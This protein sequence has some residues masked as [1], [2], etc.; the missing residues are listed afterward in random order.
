MP[1]NRSVRRSPQF[2][3]AE[4]A[5]GVVGSS[6]R[7]VSASRPSPRARPTGSRSAIANGKS[8]PTTTWVRPKRS[9]RLADRAV[10]VDEAVD[11]E[12]RAPSRPDRPCTASRSAGKVSQACAQA[13]QQRAERAAA[14]A[15]GDAQARMP[16]RACRRSAARRPRARSRPGRPAPAAAAAGRPGAPC[17]TGRSGCT[18]IAAPSRSAAAKNG[19]S[20][21]SPRTTPLMLVPISTPARPSGAHQRVRARRRAVDVLQRHRAE[22]EE[23]AG[24]ARHHAGDLLV[25]VARQAP[26]RPRRRAS[27]TAAP[28]SATA[29]ADRPAARPCR[30]HASRRP[31]MCRA[32]CGRPC[33]RASRG[34]G[35]RAPAPS[36]ARRRRARRAHTAGSP[37][38]RRGCGC[39]CRTIAVAHD[40]D[41]PVLADTTNPS[42]DVSMISALASRRFRKHRE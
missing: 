4:P 12:L 13:R 3:D 33:P 20:F 17:R 16:R 23:A 22:A 42:K 10:F 11:P 9:I 24:L 29:P 19:S 37:P 36:T 8:E 15:E 30:R 26:R 6:R 32:P 1:R 14:V 28:A 2:G 7:S 21:G 27:T 40:V 41:L 35:R 34:D 5:Q 38:A 31:T 25:Q 39:R 18:K